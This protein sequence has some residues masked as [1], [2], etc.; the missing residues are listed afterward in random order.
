MATPLLNISPLDGRYAKQIDSLRNHLSEFGLIKTRVEVEIHWLISLGNN[1]KIKEVKKFNASAQKKL[2]SVIDKFSEKDAA[3]IKQIES[4]TNHDVKAVEY[5]LKKTLKKQKDVAPYLEFIHF[6]CTSEDINNLSYALMTKRAVNE[7][8]LP[9]LSEIYVKIQSYAKQYAA[10]AILARTHGQSA[11]PTTM[12]KEFANVAARL[13]RQINQLAKQ[14]YLGKINGAVGN[15]NAHV[16]AYPEVNWEQHSKDFIKSLGLT[17][18]PMTTQ[19]EPHDFLS[20]IFNTIA[21][22]NT[23]LIDFNRDLWGYI[24]LGYFKQKLKKNEVGSSTMPHKVNPIDFE[25]S[26][27]NLGLSNSIL[28]HLSEKLPISRWQRDLSDST[29]LR[30]IGVGFG[31]HGLAIN[32]CLKGLNKLEIN[33]QV[34]DDDLNHAW[35]VLAEPIQTVMRRYGIPEPYEKLKALTRGNQHINEEVLHSFIQNLDIPQKAKK[36]LINLRPENYIG[37]ANKLAKKS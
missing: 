3:E 37:L 4:I 20:E 11:S 15:F 13:K 23:I 34:I 16:V 12:G 2:L 36:D 29:V 26:E 8:T 1:P 17:Y 24:S 27:G 6:A 31:Y 14:E 21:R 25:N 28:N 33:K 19:I 9:G 18:N 5:W 22:I 32:S 10:I 30:N 35:E 7:N